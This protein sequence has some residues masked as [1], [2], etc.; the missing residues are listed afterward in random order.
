MPDMRQ[1]MSRLFAQCSAQ[2]GGY[3]ELLLIWCSDCRNGTSKRV[4]VSNT[5][6]VRGSKAEGK[7]M[8]V[9]EHF[10]VPVPSEASQEC[11]ALSAQTFGCQRTVE[12]NLSGNHWCS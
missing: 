10:P 7:M 9:S 11:S 12:Q 8:P 6:P 5:E 1:H 3:L 2:L 4:V